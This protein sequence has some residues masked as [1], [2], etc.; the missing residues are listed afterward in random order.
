MNAAQAWLD[1]AAANCEKIIAV[2]GMVLAVAALVR[3]QVKLWRAEAAGAAVTSAVTQAG[4][5]PAVRGIMAA[6]PPI[7]RATVKGWLRPPPK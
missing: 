6:A 1:F 3:A 7:L 4:A 5:E 2:V